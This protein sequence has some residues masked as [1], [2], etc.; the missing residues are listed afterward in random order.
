MAVAELTPRIQPRAVCEATQR[1]ARA[2]GLEPVAA[3]V[4]AARVRGDAEALEPVIRPRL[5]RLHAPSQMTDAGRAADRLAA[6]IAR[7]ERIGLA[8]DYDVDGITSHALLSEALTK[9]FGVP[10]ARLR[11]YI[12]H[13]LRDGYGLSDGLTD[14]ILREGP[15]EVL[16]T[17]DCGSSDH[18]R[19][20][21]L[22]AA[23]VDVIVTDHHALPAEGPPPAAHATVNPTREDCAYPDAAIAGCMV[24]WLLMAELRRRLV[25]NGRLAGD[26][27][28][29]SGLLD[30]VSLGTVADA[31]TLASPSNRAVVNAGL[32]IINRLER[33]CWRAMKTLIDRDG[34]FGTDD[35][36]FQLGPRIN[37]RGRMEDP[38][39]ALHFLQADSD[40]QAGER[41]AV[42]DANNLERRVAERAMV[43]SAR[44]A[45]ASGLTSN[46][47]SLVV[48]D[49][50]FHPGVQGIVASRL[51]ETFGRPCVV[52]SPGRD[53]GY[54]TGSMRSVPGVHAR[55]ALQHAADA[56][57]ELFAAFGGHAGA[58][59]LT[60][61]M[62][63]ID[64]FR[65]LFA[66]AVAAQIGDRR[67]H[68]VIDTDG[69]LPDGAVSEATWETLAALAPYGRGFEAPT[70]E[71]RFGVVDARAVGADQT[72]IKLV[73]E[74]VC[75]RYDAIWFGARSDA[76]APMPVA[77]G[78]RLFCVYQLDMNRYRGR[79]AL[80]LVIRYGSSV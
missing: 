8:T 4:L 43:A 35:L 3:R 36:G 9:H 23:G 62:S 1:A 48:F 18:A 5:A 56:A 68:P 28:K 52:F 55:D 27:P 29:L 22:A 79:S 44:E 25:A 53:E 70:F 74:D 2:M 42:L 47:Q 69:A 39:A 19:I 71:G 7:G 60:L 72:H 41:L 46:T 13:R 40:A 49:P 26:A 10:G 61:A 24:S 20:E 37:A 30:Y 17:A 63:G 58:A 57:P 21:R 75:G 54:V 12:G 76:A 51:V 45:V 33:P 16:V 11:H 38:Y 15:P 67:L 73:L 50:G 80:Q 66:E 32:G 34:G 65:A 77:G 59:G 78:G 31:V 64:R 14:R 6:A